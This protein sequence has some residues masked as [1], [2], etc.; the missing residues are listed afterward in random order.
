MDH[1]SCSTPR[2]EARP[3][4]ASWPPFGRL[5][6][7]PSSRQSM[8][9]RLLPACGSGRDQWA[10]VAV[11]VQ[12]RQ[13]RTARPTA[14]RFWPCSC[15]GAAPDEINGVLQ[16]WIAL[17]ARRVRVDNWGAGPGTDAWQWQW[18]G[19]EAVL[20]CALLVSSPAYGLPSKI[21]NHGPV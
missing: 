16:C 6:P 8:H 9:G 11:Q 14:T 15:R 1:T 13:A 20:P 3:G 18:H 2:G 17:P 21:I 19:G 4:K 5:R 12:A 10:A 7:A